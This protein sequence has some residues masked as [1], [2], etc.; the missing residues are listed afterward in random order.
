MTR[1]TEKEALVAIRAKGYITRF[2]GYYVNVYATQDGKT[3]SKIASLRSA[4][5]TMNADQVNA[6]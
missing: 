6:L 4:N 3:Y 2:N 5:G 1:I